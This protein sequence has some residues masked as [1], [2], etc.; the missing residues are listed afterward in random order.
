MPL[1]VNATLTAVTGA[2]AA[3]G[4]RDDWDEAPA[5]PAG[6]APSKWTGSA[7][8]YLLQRRRNVWTPDGIDIVEER[9][10]IIDSDVATVIGIDTDDVLTFTGP[11][12]DVYAARAASVAVRTAQAAGAPQ[13][14]ANGLQTTR[15][16]LTPA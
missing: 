9:A 5:G 16:D 13:R 14:V 10:L 2:S 4:G 15:I 1:Q 6:D 11:T 3:T 8:A 12:G 7:D